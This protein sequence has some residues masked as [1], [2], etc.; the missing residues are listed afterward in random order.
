MGYMGEEILLDIKKYCED[1]LRKIDEAAKKLE[2][3]MLEE[4][5]ENTPESEREYFFSRSHST[6]QNKVYFLNNI[7]LKKGWRKKAY[8]ATGSRID[9]NNYKGAVYAVEN[10]NKPKIVHLVN[11]QHRIVVH[12]HDTG[13]ML[14]PVMK[15]PEI[16]DKYQEKLNE[17]IE[18]I[19]KNG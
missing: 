1:N 11:F 4:I 15:I 9:S 10:V 16:R 8:G 17:E 7:P 13:L 3:E 18:R 5:R 6:G 14:D 12:G 2:T 19:L